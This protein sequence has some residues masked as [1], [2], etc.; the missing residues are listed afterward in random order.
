MGERRFRSA[1]VAFECC[2]TITLNHNFDPRR[3]LRLAALT[4]FSW[5]GHDFIHNLG[6]TSLL[7]LAATVRIGSVARLSLRMPRWF[8]VTDFVV[9]HFTLPV[10]LRVALRPQSQPSYHPRSHD[11]L[12]NRCTFSQP[13]KSECF[14][15]SRVNRLLRSWILAAGPVVTSR[16]FLNSVT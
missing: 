3:S 5:A 11:W 6:L 1:N 14:N 2:C 16:Y 15:G 4:E 13:S 8:F 9:S 12:R 10:F 7:S